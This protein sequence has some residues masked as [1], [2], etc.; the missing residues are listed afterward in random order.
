MDIRFIA[1]FIITIIIIIMTLLPA[2]LISST[3]TE[4]SSKIPLA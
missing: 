1:S 3:K 2:A 4:T